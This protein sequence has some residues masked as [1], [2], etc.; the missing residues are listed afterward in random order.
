M[1]NKYLNGV[2]FIIF[3]LLLL[4]IAHC[5]N[6]NSPKST[7]PVEE[8]TLKK[9]FPKKHL[10]LTANIDYLRLRDRPGKEGKVL[11]MLSKGDVVFELGEAS[12]FTTEIKLRGIWYD[13]PWIKVETKS[14]TVGWVYG[15]GLSFKLDDRNKITS[16][17]IRQR[18]KALFGKKLAGSVLEY[19]KRY[20]TAHT[21][22]EFA[23]AYQAGA[24]LR[25]SLVEIMHEKI[26]VEDYDKLP[27]LSWLEQTMPGYN[28]LLIAEGTLFHLFAN[29]NEMAEKVRKTKGKEDDEFVELGRAIYLADSIENFFPGWIVQMTDYKGCSEL[30]SGIHNRV[31]D[32]MNKTLANSDLFEIAIEKAKTALVKD[33]IDPAVTYLNSKEMILEELDAIL[34]ADYGILT[35]EDKIALRT[36]QKKFENPKENGITVNCMTIYS[37]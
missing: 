32:Q 31:L 15:G 8:V 13:D 29:F 20:E 14:G 28:A 6:D 19:R 1:I 34:S 17:L 2:K 12:D 30:G 36:R 27:D 16:L 35:A 23:V 26:A 25:D 7:P 9:D 18:L 24:S 21:S 10:P 37:E 3:S 11:E 5:K 22:S 33:I 4:S